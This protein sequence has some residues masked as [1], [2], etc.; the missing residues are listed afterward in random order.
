[1]TG[2]GRGSGVSAVL[3]VCALGCSNDSQTSADGAVDEADGGT[4]VSSAPVC[5]QDRWCWEKPLPHGVDLH[6][7]WGT[8][9]T[10]LY[11]VGDAGVIQHFDGKKWEAVFLGDGRAQFRAVWG[12]S[13]SDVFA[14]GGDLIDAQPAIWRFDG[15]QWRKVEG[16]PEGRALNGIWGSSESNVFAV[17]DGDFVIR[18]DGSQWTKMDVPSVPVQLTDIWGENEHNV[19]VV[20]SKGG[21]INSPS[22]EPV[23]WRYDGSHWN[24]MTLP[25]LE[26]VYLHAIWGRDSNNVYAAGHSVGGSL[27][28]VVLR[29]DGSSWNRIPAPGGYGVADIWGSGSSTV[30]AVVRRDFR[31]EVR[32]TVSEFDGETWSEMPVDRTVF[33]Y[34]AFG[35]PTPRLWGSGDEYIYMVGMRGIILHH[36]GREDGAWTVTQGDADGSRLN[37]VWSV[38]QTDAFAVGRRADNRG[39]ID[40]IIFRKR[41]NGWTAMETPPMGDLSAIWGTSASDLFAVGKARENEDSGALHFDGV[42]WS[43]IPGGAS[44]NAVWGTGPKKVYVAGDGISLYDGTE[45]TDESPPSSGPWVSIHGSGASNVVAVSDEGSVVRFDGATWIEIPSSEISGEPQAIWTFGP[46]NIYVA[47]SPDPEG[48]HLWHYDGEGWSGIAFPDARYAPVNAIWGRSPNDIYVAGILGRI[49]HYDGID[50]SPMAS[51]TRW[52]V[53]SLS[54]DASGTIRAAGTVGTILVRRP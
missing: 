43:A 5:T 25:E 52:E 17:G 10:D 42:T 31:P 16:L 18:F 15:S 23:I 47:V 39:A 30:K 19:F 4:P 45:W 8:S 27:R 9:A 14:V 44:G 34:A 24:E 29:Y 40:G 49:W 21:N 1:M 32:W 35:M 2:L 12:S 11:A 50:W 48:V 36:D 37:G 41:G 38:S 28:S 51:G 6:G 22:V 54:G 20:G 53:L 26:G 7:V 13:S 33:M 46:E 3:F